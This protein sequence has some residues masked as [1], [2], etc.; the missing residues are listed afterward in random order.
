MGTNALTAI[1]V[2]LV[3]SCALVS[4]WFINKLTIKWAM[5]VSMLGYSFFVAAQFYPTYYT[6]LPAAII[7]GL[8][9]APMWSA[10]CTFFTEVCWIKL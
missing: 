6:L 3:V 4:T 5:V 8:A 2:A 10:K 7:M 9:A 1:Y